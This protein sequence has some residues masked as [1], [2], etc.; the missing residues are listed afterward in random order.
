M[1]NILITGCTGFVG[2]HILESFENNSDESINIIAS[3]RNKL[4][5]NKEYQQNALE[6]DLKDNNYIKKITK[7]ADII[8][9]T[10][11]WAELNGNIKNSQENFLF[12]TINLI[13]QAIENKVKRFIFLSAITSNPIV[14]NKLH[15]KLELNK[16]WAHYA[17]IIRI[18]KYLEKVSEDKIEIIILRVGYFTGKNYSLGILPILLPRLKT[19]LVPWIENG[20]TT[21]PLVDGEDIAQS[22]KLASLVTLRNTFNTIDVVG[23][24]TPTVKE[25]F[26]YLNK[27]YKYPLPHFSVSYEIAYL[28]A[29]FMR[30]LYKI[31]PFDPLLVPSVVL[32]LEE[33]NSTNKKA[34][35]ILGYMPKIDWKDSLDIQ[36]EEMKIRQIK[37]MKMNLS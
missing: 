4:K 9:H 7:K 28:F 20:N 12:P 11:S 3:C 37:N 34:K 6:G 15:T 19:H 17:S 5:L 24:S 10:A 1:K 30:S 31:L 27:K 35:D 2:S 32:L 14:D 23:K 25:V 22:F 16:I 36:I 13:N 29:R 33:T 18:E 8:C 21:L 26:K